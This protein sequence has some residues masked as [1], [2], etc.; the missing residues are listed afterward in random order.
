MG[1][2]RE[3][4]E[5]E[6]CGEVKY[7]IVLIY[8]KLVFWKILTS[9]S[10]NLS[11]YPQSKPNHRTQFTTALR[12]VKEAFRRGQGSADSPRSDRGHPRSREPLDTSHNKQITSFRCNLASEQKWQ[13]P[14]GEAA[15][16]QFVLY[17][18]LVSIFQNTNFG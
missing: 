7:K 9:L 14:C 12:D 3:D 2:E 17:E 6:G 10:Y 16:E 4:R 5:I 15:W 11:F 13:P 1:R 8:P 18:R